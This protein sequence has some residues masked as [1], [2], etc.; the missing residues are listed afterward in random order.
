MRQSC[1]ASTNTIRQ[2]TKPEV[3]PPLARWQH[4][5]TT[6]QFGRRPAVSTISGLPSPPAPTRRPGP[7]AVTSCLQ[8]AAADP[9]RTPGAPETRRHPSSCSCGGTSSGASSAAGSAS[10]GRLS[11]GR[12]SGAPRGRRVGCQSPRAAGRPLPASCGLECQHPGSTQRQECAAVCSGHRHRCS[13]QRARLYPPSRHL[14]PRVLPA[15]CGDCGPSA[16][17]SRA[18]LARWLPASPGVSQQ[19][20]GRTVPRAARRAPLFPIR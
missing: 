19:H 17:E 3:L 20:A 10:S 7:R 5:P 15:D 18:V 6:T 9:P 14:S 2:Q 8:A 1:S 12:R 4:V 13:S 16:P 11:A